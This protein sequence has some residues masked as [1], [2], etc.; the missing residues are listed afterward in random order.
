MKDH[1]KRT[2]QSISST[3]PMSVSTPGDSSTSRVLEEEDDIQPVDNLQALL[4][5]KLRQEN[6]GTAGSLRAKLDRLEQTKL[7]IQ[8]KIDAI[9]QAIIVLE[10]EDEA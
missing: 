7:Q 4:H 6:T 5:S 3:S 10:D 9:K 2:H 1:Y 8:I